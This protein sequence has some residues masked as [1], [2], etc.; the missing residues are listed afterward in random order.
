LPAEVLGLTSTNS[1]HATTEDREWE[2]YG[3]NFMDQALG[4]KLFANSIQKG[5][6]LL[7]DSN[8]TTTRQ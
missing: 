1:A 4:R 6:E 8:T 3:L 7:P 2:Q 5:I